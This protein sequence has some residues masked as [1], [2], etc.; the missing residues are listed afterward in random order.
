MQ[1][2]ITVDE[3]ASN[4]VSSVQDNLALHVALNADTWCIVD[5]LGAL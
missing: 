1:T 4:R 2:M 3:P 5:S